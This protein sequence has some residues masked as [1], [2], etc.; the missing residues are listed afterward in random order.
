MIDTIILSAGLIGGVGGESCRAVASHAINNGFTAI[1]KIYTK[2]LHGEVVGFANIIQKFLSNKSD[3]DI[4]NY[5]DFLN[6]ISAPSTLSD[7]SF[8]DLEDS[9]MDRIVNKAMYKGDTLWNHPELI[10]FEKLKNTIYLA[11]KLS[12]E[13][14]CNGL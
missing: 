11:N 9:D 13:R 14:R 8:G 2:S 5:I 6:S 3:D 4:I 1:P 10:S 12:L 7:L